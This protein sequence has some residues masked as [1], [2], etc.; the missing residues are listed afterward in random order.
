MRKC[1]LKA[2]RQFSSRCA[3]MM[4]KLLKGEPLSQQEMNQLDQMMNM[5]GMTDMRYQNWLARQMEEALNFPEVR[6][7]M[8]ELM[9]ACCA[10]WA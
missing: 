2:L 4:E 5:D 10:R 9:P 8:E 3:K 7:A 1:W 6:K